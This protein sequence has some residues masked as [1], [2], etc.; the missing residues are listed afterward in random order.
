MQL[1]QCHTAQIFAISN[2]FARHTGAQMHGPEVKRL[3]GAQVGRFGL[4][5]DVTLAIRANLAVLQT[6]QEQIDIVEKRLMR[7]V[8]LNPDYALLNTVPGIGPVLATTIML[9][10]GTISRFATVG[11]FS[12]YC[13]CVD[14][15]RDSNRRKKGEGN[16]K[17]GN[18]YLAWAFVEAATSRSVRVRKPG[19]FTNARSACA[20]ASLRSRHWRTTWLAP[21]ITCFGSTNHLRQ[22]AV[23]AS[24]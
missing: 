4:A 24:R 6:L 12:S 23:L 13:R 8:K 11:H 7:Q 19:A 17:N 14:S 3:D 18:R 2:L 22:F 15:R 20:T 9:E 1:V 5:P 10:T 21:A 16:T